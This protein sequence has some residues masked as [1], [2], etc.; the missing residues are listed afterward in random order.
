MEVK[1]KAAEMNQVNLPP[2]LQG[3]LRRL[4]GEIPYGIS[5]EL[6]GR[7]YKCEDPDSFYAE[8]MAYLDDLRR[9]GV[10]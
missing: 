3:C 2:A 5:V 4:K 9:N 7:R 1:T 10:V 8:V 6:Q